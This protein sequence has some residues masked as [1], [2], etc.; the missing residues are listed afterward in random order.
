VGKLYLIKT[1]SIDFKRKSNE[2]LLKTSNLQHS[3]IILYISSG[4]SCG[5]FSLFPF[6]ICSIDSILES[7][8]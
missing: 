8:E 6:N 1:D 2:G 5:I 4:Q 3:S 7:P